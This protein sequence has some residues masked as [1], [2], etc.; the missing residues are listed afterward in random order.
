[1]DRTLIETERSVASFLTEARSNKRVWRGLQKTL[2]R[3][4]EEGVHGE[5]AY[6]LARRSLTETVRV[7]TEDARIVS[8]KLETRTT[9]TLKAQRELLS[10]L[11][12]S[13]RASLL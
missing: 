4:L 7:Q 1:M 10:Q 9:L 13:E 2:Q 3:R 8:P 11:T 12:T 6:E 5:C